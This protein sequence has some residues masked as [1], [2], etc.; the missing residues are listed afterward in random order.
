VFEAWQR[1]LTE[2]LG[3]IK[4]PSVAEGIAAA[5]PLRGCEILACVLASDGFIIA[6]EDE[7]IW[8]R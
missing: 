6:V 1:N 4:R 5:N 7:E 8:P 2:V 3:V